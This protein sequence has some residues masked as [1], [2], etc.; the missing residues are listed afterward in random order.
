MECS[1]TAASMAKIAK[2]AM[3][4]VAMNYKVG[5]ETCNCPNKAAAL[6]KDS[7]AKQEYVIGD[8]VT[9]CSVDAKIKLAHAKYRAAVTALAKAQAEKTEAAAS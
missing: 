6:A 2:E 1:K 3:A 8:E 5:E 4:T 7:G 9:C